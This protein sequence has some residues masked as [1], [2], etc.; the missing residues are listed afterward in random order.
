LALVFI[1]V[2][3]GLASV[4]PIFDVLLPDAAMRI[5]VRSTERHH[6]DW[7]G[8]L[9]RWFQRAIGIDPR[10]EPSRDPGSRR[11]VRVLGLVL[12]FSIWAIARAL[13]AATA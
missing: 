9:G 6:D 4:Y 10:T 11:R 3:A 2:G 1:V 12:L 5:Q 13:I 7:R 8:G